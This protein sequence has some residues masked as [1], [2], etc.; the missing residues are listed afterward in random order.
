MRDK[1]VTEQECKEFLDFMEQYENKKKNK[2]LLLKKIKE[3]LQWHNFMK[4]MH[5][6]KK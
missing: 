3:K 4:W 1:I 2:Y 5:N 6:L